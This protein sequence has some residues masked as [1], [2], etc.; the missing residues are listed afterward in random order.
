[1]P[2]L[3]PVKTYDDD[4][5]FMRQALE[6]AA[7]GLG[8]VAP[9]PSVGCLIVKNGEIA[10]QA[11]SADGGRP[12]AETQALKQAG[13]AAKG[14]TAYITLEP[15]GHHGATP[16]CVGALIEAGIARVVIACLDPNQQ[17]NDC[18]AK[19]EAAGIEVT[20]GICEEQA[21]ALNEGFFKVVTQGRPL[22]TAKVATTLDGRIATRTGESKWI[23]GEEA[24]RKVHEY[25]AQ[26]DAV[27]IGVGTVLA[28]DPQLTVRL[29][30]IDS[31]PTRI[32]IDHDLKTPVDSHLVKTATDENVWFVCGEQAEQGRFSDAGAKVIRL[33]SKDRHFSPE[34]LL[35]ELA[36]QGL[37]R[38][39]IEGGGQTITGFLRA[40]MIDRLLWFRAPKL[41]GG[42]GLPAFQAL[43]I[44]TMDEA[45]NFSLEDR[46]AL[47]EDLLEI[48]RLNG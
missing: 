33:Q 7:Q 29:D 16:P 2:E 21:R 10:G 1:M 17:G 25:R 34:I 38:L 23:T 11:R 37:T 47:G 22:V 44:E 12:H 5:K 14:A 20:Q 45:L 35:K 4:F 46:M 27:L 39:F 32:V 18:I 8:R 48:W 28:D 40:G 15:C 13:A 31:Q 36:A 41:I 6:L 26:H 30:E 42:D 3:N 9:N 43:D 19:L 24:R